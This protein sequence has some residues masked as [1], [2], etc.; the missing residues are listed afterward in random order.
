MQD[1]LAYKCQAYSAENHKNCNRKYQV[2]ECCRRVRDQRWLSET[3]ADKEHF[4]LSCFK[5]AFSTYEYMECIQQYIQWVI[6]KKSLKEEVEMGSDCSIR[7]IG[8]YKLQNLI[9]T[10]QYSA[11]QY[12]SNTTNF[13]FEQWI[14]GGK[15]GAGKLTQST[16]RILHE[17]EVC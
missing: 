10:E 9:Q 6:L 7:K 11:L 5:N 15:N 17:G 2:V 13:Y 3:K 4:V 12:S 8:D 14:V 1:G 16:F